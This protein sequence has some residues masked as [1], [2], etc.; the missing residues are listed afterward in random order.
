MQIYGRPTLPTTEISTKEQRLSPAYSKQKKSL[1]LQKTRFPRLV[2]GTFLVRDAI[3]I[4]GSINLPPILN[5]ITPN[6]LFSSPAV[7]MAVI[8][9][10]T[11]VFSQIF[12][13]PVHLLGLDLYS[14]LHSTNRQRVSRIKGSLGPITAMRCSRIIPAFG[15]GL[16]LN[17]GLRDYLHRVV[18]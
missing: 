13:T 17:T 8:Q 11:P 18:G 15:V 16:V 14:N 5:S 4:F 7:Q 2:G 9:M 10:F 3:T 6:S 1:Q 12:A